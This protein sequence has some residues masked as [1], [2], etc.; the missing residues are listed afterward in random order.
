MDLDD[1][2]LDYY[3]DRRRA[4]GW[5]N[6]QPFNAFLGLPRSI[7]MPLFTTEKRDALWSARKD[8]LVHTSCDKAVD[9]I[10]R[11]YQVLRPVKDL[12]GF[13]TRKRADFGGLEKKLSDSTRW[14]ASN[15]NPVRCSTYDHRLRG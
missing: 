2:K 8:V 11:G 10:T 4:A 13:K 3:I 12:P 5:G 14:A 9:P 15:L 1:T 6:S 7:R